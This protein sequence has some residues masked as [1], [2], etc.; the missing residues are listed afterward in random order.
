MMAAQN[1]AVEHARQKN[2]VGKLRLARALSTGIDLAEG[3]AD[4][5]ERLSVVAVFV[6]RSNPATKRHKKHKRDFT[7][8]KGDR[9]RWRSFPSHPSCAFCAFLWLVLF[10]TI[11]ALARQFHFFT[12][13]PRRRQLDRLVDFYVAGAATKISGQRFLDLIAR[14]ARFLVQ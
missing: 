7:Q 9:C 1:L 12:T 11:Q 13:P 4:Y 10:Q 2:V 14:G 6:H 3:F 8:A 5:L